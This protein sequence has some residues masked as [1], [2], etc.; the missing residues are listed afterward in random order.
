MKTQKLQKTNR[1]QPDAAREFKIKVA[2]LKK[3]L[4]QQD[5]ADDLGIK[6]A[7]V[8]MFVKGYGASKRFTQWC[9][10]NLNLDV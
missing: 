8:S 7:S 3:G 2:L 6:A 10:E 4:K 5:I 1:Q 9:K